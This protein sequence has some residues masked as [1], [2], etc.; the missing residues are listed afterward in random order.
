MQ[1]IAK[2]VTSHIAVGILLAMCLSEAT[3]QKAAATVQTVAEPLQINLVRSKVVLDGSREVLESAAVAKPGEILEE[4]ATYTNTS[5]AALK[6]LEATLPV[7]PNTELVMASVK[8]S[9]AKA[10]TDG[11]TFS[12]LPLTRKIKQANGV[13]VEL[14]VPLSEYRYLRWYPGELAPNKPISFSARFKVADSPVAANNAG[15]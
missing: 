5:K 9:N 7:P 13:E 3:A 8:P 14:P 1:R 11:K 10:S 15:K 12:A 4:V 6:K 2:L